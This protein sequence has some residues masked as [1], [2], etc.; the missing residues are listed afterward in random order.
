MT[1]VAGGTHSRSRFRRDPR[2][3][4]LLEGAILLPA[5][6]LLLFPEAL[7]AATVGV[8]LA[9]AAVWLISLALF[10]SLLPATPFSLLFLLWGGALIVG[11]LV[12]VDPVETLPKATGLILGLAVWRYVVIATQTRRRLA[13]AVALFLLLSLG[14]TL[15]GALNMRELPKIPLLSA[16]NPFQ[17]ATLPGLSNLAVHPNQLAAMICIYL[18]LLFSLSFGPAGGRYPRRLRLALALLA[19]LTVL[20]LVLTQS[21]G[22]WVGAAAG[23]FAL[24]VLWAVVLPPTRARR[25]AR[26]LAVVI[27]VAA[28]G[29]LLWIGPGRV[30]Q[31]WLDPPLE[32]ALGTFSTLNYR[33]ALWPWAVTAIGDFPFTG[34]G[35]GAFRQVVFRFYP[36]TMTP[37]PD[38]GHAHNIFLQTAL[39]VGLPGL[40]I[41]GAILLVA[42]AVGWRVARRD[43][44]F[45]PVA[46]GLLAG[47]MGLHVFGLADALVLGSK[48]GLVFWFALGLLAAMNKEELAP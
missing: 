46:L 34:V 31:L 3:L 8:L 26:L 37:D 40:V 18:P 30:R 1:T 11:I 24:L 20:V 5:I 23:L 12:S 19:A 21:R 35:L 2:P 33:Q 39:D 38:V 36:I 22:G 6:P 45:R 7:P 17:T 25:A 42:S 28:L 15:L 10:P 9:L 14:F 41:Y 27:V 29:A 4:I 16:L 32:S 48:M 47:L 43:V 13:V 44:G